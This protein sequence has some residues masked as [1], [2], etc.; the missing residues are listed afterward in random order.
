MLPGFKFLFAVLLTLAGALLVGCAGPVAPPPGNGVLPA[1]PVWQEPT[2]PPAATATTAVSPTTAALADA[3]AASADKPAAPVFTPM[4]TP[5][6]PTYTP[7]PAPT[8]LGDADAER[9]AAPA[10]QAVTLDGT[11]VYLEDLRGT[12]T[13]LAFWAPW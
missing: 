12:P 4:P 1:A 11:A 8:R 2:L 5:A 7:R 3:A 6:R 10:F 9:P 13:L